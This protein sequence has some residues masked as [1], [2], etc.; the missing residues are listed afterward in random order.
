[1]RETRA[2]SRWRGW[3]FCFGLAL[4]LSGS[5]AAVPVDT[6]WV[7]TNLELLR[8][9]LGSGALLERLPAA[10]KTRAVAIDHANARV[11]TFDDSATC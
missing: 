11:W 5:A 4:L 6:L 1:M 9:E 3:A 2:N 10:M 8:L 7:G